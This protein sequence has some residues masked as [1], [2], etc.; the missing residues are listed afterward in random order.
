MKKKSKR[1]QPASTQSSKNSINNR[2][3]AVITYLFLG[4]FIC[5][6]GYMVY[7]QLMK[8]E[9]FINSPYNSRQDSFA[10]R[11][12]R[13][14]ILSADRKILAQTNADEQGN[15][16]RYYPYSNLYAHVVGFASNG[17]SGIE[18][19]M[20]FNL[21]R[22]HTFVLDRLVN[23]IKNEKSI[24]DN[25][26]TTLNSSL[27]ETAYNALGDYD[28]AV[29]ILEPSTGKILA[30]VSKPDFDPNTIEQNWKSITSGDSSQSVLLNR[31]TQGLYPPGSTFK[32]FTTL[33]YMR[34]NP[35]YSAFAYD[36]D[37]STSVDNT[38]I[39]CYGNEAHG[40]EDL[41]AAFANSCNSAYATIGMSLQKNQFAS[42][43]N[44]LL[45]NTTLPGNFTTAKS[46]FTLT[47]NSPDGLV[48]QTAIG[49]GETLVTPLHMALLTSAIANNGVLMKPYVVD[50]TE[51]E[52]G[53]VV[54]SYAPAVYDDSFLS[55]D[56]TAVLKD[57][58]QY[59]VTNG[60]GEKLNGATYTAAGK[61]GSAEFSNDKSE[62]HS[63]F[64]GY[65]HRD[66]KTDIAVAIIAEGAGTGSTYA[67][68][69]AKQIFDAY[70]SE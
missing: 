63:W 35:N 64:I 46:S 26:V 62:S 14:E 2:E 23:E 39:H 53:V 17:K 34:E 55:K 59:V 11:V 49:Q 54:K 31:A 66:D 67:V 5:L 33:E 42:L 56:E 41:K 36:C 50:H 8:S 10:T 28:G 48:M 43:C 24:G 20:N 21:L 58:M 61:T 52:S 27:Q 30:M 40:Q 70:Y 60:T 68:P 32:I 1:K 29:I 38:T 65:A 47:D 22:S 45:F 69:V 16:T 18:S 13:G 57:Y 6:M 25:V 15:E 51:N 19:T 4:I 3:F 9:D 37:G 7:F 44:S 12:V